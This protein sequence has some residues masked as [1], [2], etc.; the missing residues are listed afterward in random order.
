[1]ISGVSLG[2]DHFFY[3]NPLESNGEHSR[4]E[5]FGCACCPSNVCRFIPSVPGYIYGQTDSRLYVNLFIQSKVQVT[6]GGEK[7]EIEQSSKNP[8]DG[9]VKFSINPEN[10]KSF[11]LALRIPGWL[12]DKP[13]PGSLYRFATASEK[14]GSCQGSPGR[15]TRY[16]RLFSA[17]HSV[18]QTSP[19]PGPCT[20]YRRRNTGGG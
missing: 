7:L 12:S 5:W 3:P 2:S 13:I 6:M 17:V 15:N 10:A 19:F 18:R 14:K 1:M 11:E 20:R 9:E 16:T 8:W 4:S